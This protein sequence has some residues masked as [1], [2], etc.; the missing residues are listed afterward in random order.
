[1]TCE[2]LPKKT[3]LSFNQ[4]SFYKVNFDIVDDKFENLQWEEILKEEVNKLITE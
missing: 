2:R 1:M 3:K 4:E